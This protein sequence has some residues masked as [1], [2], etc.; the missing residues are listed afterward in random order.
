M[1][2]RCTFIAAIVAVVVTSIS[3]NNCNLFDKS[4][5]F[6]C[7]AGY[8]IHKITAW[9]SN[10][11]EDR[12][13]CYKCHSINPRGTSQCYWTGYVNNFDKVVK[14]RCKSD[15]YIA[16]VKSYHSNKKEDRRF[17]FKCCKT[18]GRCIGHCL[19]TPLV[20]Q[21]DKDMKYQVETNHV[22]VGAYSYHNNHKE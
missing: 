9:H 8:S 4:H 6:E 5:K 1:Y 16:G 15:H 7:P 14:A 13:Y 22:I 11:H 19:I 21:F 20:N 10:K 2:H 3:G 17:D 18:I 12:V